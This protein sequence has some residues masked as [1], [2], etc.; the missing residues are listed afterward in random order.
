MYCMQALTLSTNLTNTEKLRSKGT[1]GN[2]LRD[3]DQYFTSRTLQHI[4]AAHQPKSPAGL[5]VATT[6][7]EPIMP[8]ARTL[9]K[10]LCVQ[11]CSL[12]GNQEQCRAEARSR[13]Q[14]IALYE[15]G[16]E[17]LAGI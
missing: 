8:H 9:N 1:T 5:A 16:C 10:R 14:A 2:G 7:L 15:A 11:A 13:H 4:K 6:A 17:M 3:G 12:H